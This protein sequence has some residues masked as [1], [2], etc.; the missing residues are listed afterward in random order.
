MRR[1]LA[2]FLLLVV[3]ASW[4]AAQDLLPDE[5]H[6]L[7]L[8]AQGRYREARDVFLELLA[9]EAGERD[10]RSAALAEFHATMA[11]L[12]SERIANDGITRSALTAARDSGLAGL[13]KV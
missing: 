6:A 13:G 5:V 7:D 10:A 4:G 8:K 9:R 12:L 11:T 1:P 3:S 2:P